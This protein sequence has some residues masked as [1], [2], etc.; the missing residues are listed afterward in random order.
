MSDLTVL[1][2]GEA[3]TDVVIGADGAEEARPGGSPANIAVGLA[4]LG[5]ATDL[6]CRIGPDAYG[7]ELRSHLEQA[8]VGLVPAISAG[9]D[10][11]STAVARIGPDGAAIYSFDIDWDPGPIS[12]G[13]VR[14]LHTGSLAMVL[15]P[16][17]SE[18]SA[19]LSAATP[20][21]LVSLDPNIRPSLCLPRD[22]ALARF[23]VAIGRAHLVKMSD[24]DLE[25][26]Y[27][28]ASPGEVA[29]RMHGAGVR[30]FVVT[31]GA[32]GCFLST[33][34]WSGRM[35]AEPT[36]MVDT[37]GAGDAFMSGLLYAVL[38]KDGDESVRTGDLRRR[39]VEG[40]ARIALR[41]AALTVGRHGAQPPHLAEL[42]TR[43]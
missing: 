26:L 2:V 7:D 15:E 22:E 27:P 37:I 41:S 11:T 20:S 24:E 5:V 42:R 10:R 23:E 14:A 39:T 25:W 1:V 34:E 29:A 19:A 30:L 36:S 16:G 38:S 12:V 17:A 40:W 31:L 21:T 9:L 32:C 3:L 35:P 33:A 6:L 28:G 4:R 43:T 18:V 13:E 8:G